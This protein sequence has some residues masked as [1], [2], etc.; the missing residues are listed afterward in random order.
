MKKSPTTEKRTVD[1]VATLGDVVGSVCHG[2][3]VNRNQWENNRAG[4]SSEE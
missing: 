1:I 4:H 3:R 2:V